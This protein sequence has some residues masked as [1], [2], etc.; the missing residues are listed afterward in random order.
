MLSCF[1]DCNVLVRMWGKPSSNASAIKGCT[2]TCAFNIGYACLFSCASLCDIK[3]LHQCH[4]L[5]WNYLGILRHVSTVHFVQSLISAHHKYCR[6]SQV[7]RWQRTR[8]TWQGRNNT[9]LLWLDSIL[10]CVSSW[11]KKYKRY[12]DTRIMGSY[13]QKCIPRCLT[14]G[15]KVLTRIVTAP[16]LSVSGW[17][18]GSHS[19]R[20]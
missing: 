17:R 15:M 12:P 2:F 1:R 7:C 19:K 11:S 14:C 8:H 5:S 3:C 18:K 20:Q 6:N 16:K 10:Q 13:C 9:K 4:I